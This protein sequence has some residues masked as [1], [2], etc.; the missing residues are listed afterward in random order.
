MTMPIRAALRPLLSALWSAVPLL[1]FHFGLWAQPQDNQNS[2]DR[3]DRLAELYLNRDYLRTMCDS[4]Q[5]AHRTLLFYFHGSWCPAC[6]NMEEFVFPD[7]DVST[8]L[9]TGF[10]FVP[11]DGRLDFDGIEMAQKFGIEIYPTLV[12][13]GNDGKALERLIGYHGEVELLEKLGR[14]RSRR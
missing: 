1:F 13:V 8:A 6:R 10:L 4:A 7:V 2:S 9:Q 3:A 12:A 14:I 11:L 5:K